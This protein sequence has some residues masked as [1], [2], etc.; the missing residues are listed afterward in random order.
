MSQSGVCRAARIYGFVSAG[1]LSSGQNG[2]LALV[3]PLEVAEMSCD[4]VSTRVT[5]TA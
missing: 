1:T 4:V 2:Y 3:K 5:S